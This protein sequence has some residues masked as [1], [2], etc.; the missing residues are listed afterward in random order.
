[1]RFSPFALL[2]GAA[3]LAVVASAEDAEAQED[4]YFDG[5]KVPPMLELT[6]SNY[7]KEINA[8]K[9]LLVKHYR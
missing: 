7:E 4:T 3:T 1:M 2:F 6:E 5:K 8:S 9:W